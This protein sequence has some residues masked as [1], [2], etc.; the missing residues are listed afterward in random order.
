ME[1]TFCGDVSHKH[2]NKE[3]LLY[4]WARKIRNLGKVVFLELYDRS[5]IVQLVC[6]KKL[7][8]SCFE[9]ISTLRKESVIKVVG[10]VARRPSGTENKKIK[11][12]DFEVRISEVEVLNEA[13]PLP[14][15]LDERIKVN[16]D[17][18]LK[19]RYLDLRRESMRDVMI[20]RH[21]VMKAF[22]DFFDSEGFL[23][24]ETPY[25]GRSTPEGARD[26][27]VPSRHHR[28]EFYALTQSPQLY[29]QLLMISGVEKYFQFAR[30]FRDEDLRPERQPE[31]TQLDIEMSF[32]DMNDVISITEKAI[33]YVFDTVLKIDLEIPFPKIDYMDAILRYGSD[34]PDL[35]FD[36]QLV[37]LAKNV[38][39]YNIVGLNGKNLS[40]KLA[41]KYVS[42]LNKL[43]VDVGAKRLL[44]LTRDVSSVLPKDIAPLERN[45]IV[46]SLDLSDDD[47]GLIAVGHG[48]TPF[49]ALGK[50]RQEI[51][52]RFYINGDKQTTFYFSWVVNFPLF[53]K[54]DNGL[55]PMHHPFTAPVD[56][57]IAKF[58]ENPELV[59]AK[60]YDLVLNGW[61]IAGGS[62]RNHKR[63]LQEKIF[64]LLGYSK[65]EYTALFGFLL[66]ALSFGAP[67]HGGLAFGLDRFIST[68]KGRQSI[69]DVIAFPK[70]R[71]F[72]CLVTDAPSKVS[73]DQLDELGIIV[74]SED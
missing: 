8:E 59:R 19:Y 16:E 41:S 74:T 61:E 58:D 22:F 66:D 30:C 35:R 39:H 70:N 68:L 51:I 40:G 38:N 31:F 50:I 55:E 7:S 71:A 52:N 27:L 53:E 24:V 11:T 15:G 72:R 34:K 9:K 36:L 44:V 32:V 6:S 29:K 54:T 57:D 42:Y 45:T 48:L 67:P 1:R 63:T 21:K 20:F 5:G 26:F 37:N 28:G 13:S 47:V 46:Q 60:A 43:A 3:I 62:I 49:L 14:F 12:G 64:E 25:L 10:T 73:P 17:I 65:A 33:K 56:E 18:R 4:G 2:L 69:R 23:Y